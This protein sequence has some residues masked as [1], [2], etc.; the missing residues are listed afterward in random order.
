MEDVLKIAL[1]V[2]MYMSPAI[3]VAG[4]SVLSAYI[5]KYKRKNRKL[6]K[7]INEAKKDKSDTACS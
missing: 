7:E 6:Q 3:Y 4:L 2:L 5:V 1:Y